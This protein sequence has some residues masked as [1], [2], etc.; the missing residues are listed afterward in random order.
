MS[1]KIHSSVQKKLCR[2]KLFL[3]FKIFKKRWFIQVYIPGVMRQQKQNNFKLDMWK[4]TVLSKEI[5][6]C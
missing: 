1:Q 4:K 5:L 2:K 6:P 3:L